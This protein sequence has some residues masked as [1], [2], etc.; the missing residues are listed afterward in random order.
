MQSERTG[1]AAV[2]DMFTPSQIRLLKI[3]VIVMGVILLAG[4][5]AVIGRIVYLVNSGPR[6][7]AAA[8]QLS[9]QLPAAVALPAGASIRHIA[10]SG[11][12]LAIHYEAP[13][14]SGI[15]IVDL[16]GTGS[17]WTVPLVTAPADA[18]GKRP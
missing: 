6:P 7:D 1:D 17:G 5:V 12:R 18:A 9:G 10:L 14:G 3:A 13:G 15:R 11:N 16:G 2:P 8:G 4:L